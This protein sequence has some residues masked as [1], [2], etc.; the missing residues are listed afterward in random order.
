MNDEGDIGVGIVDLGARNRQKAG[1]H[2]DRKDQL[3]S[4]AKP[5][6]SKEAIDRSVPDVL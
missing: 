6:K 4:P 2:I 5:G 1:I 3:S